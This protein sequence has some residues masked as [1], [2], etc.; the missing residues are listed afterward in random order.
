MIS[1]SLF[2]GTTE[3]VVEHVESIVDTTGA[4][5][6]PRLHPPQVEPALAVAHE[7]HSAVELPQ[8]VLEGEGVHVDPGGGNER[9][10]GA[11]GRG[12]RTGRHEMV[13]ELDRG[14]RP[15]LLDGVGDAQVDALTAGER[16]FAHQGLADLLLDEQV[17]GRVI[18]RK[19][20]D[21]VTALS[22]FERVE[23]IVL[24]GTRHGRERVEGE[25]PTD[26]RR[27]CQHLAVLGTEQIEPTSDDEPHALRHLGVADLEPR[28]PRPVVI[29]QS[30]AVP[31]VAEQLLG[32]EGVALG[33]GEHQV[34][35]LR[36]RLAPGPGREHGLHLLAREQLRPE[37]GGAD[38][39]EHRPDGC[40]ERTAGLE[41]VV[42]ERP[43]HEHR[44][45][46]GS[47]TD[48]TQQQQRRLVGPVEILEGEH[49]RLVVGRRAR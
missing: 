2:A 46:R 35:Q 41:F 24:V 49:H 33:L 12:G 17:V 43:D 21:Q 16:Q 6:R 32:E 15:E 3:F 29:E 4:A 18:G 19:L 26:H 8:C 22:R 10:H 7:R 45:T 30:T 40:G 28:A 23:Q 42:A 14:S 9:G 48:V 36:R 11:I 34:D 47:T 27:R 5:Q 20:L 1:C 38:I 39:T 31:K 44:N 13:R 37:I 25:R